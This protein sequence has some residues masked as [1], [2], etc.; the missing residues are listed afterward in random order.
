MAK[1]EPPPEPIF[2]ATPAEF[3]K[4]LRKNHDKQS[5]LWVGYHRKA[6]GRPSIT[7]PESVDEALCVGWIDG[8]RKRWD[9]DSYMIRFTPR[10]ERSTW[11]AINIA[12][13]AELT[14]AGRM[15]PAGLAA[16]ARR[17][18]DRSEIYA[19]EQRANAK[20]DDAAEQRLRA[21][22]KAWTFF[23]AQPPSYRKLMAWWII[24]AKRPET[25]EKRL[26]RLIEESA[27]GR[28]L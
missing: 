28:R 7:W 23:Q 1:S 3:R 6:T 11:S 19:Y 10:K 22:A 2:F 18:D 24:S 17:T 13:I 25:R 26:V 12:R 5:V 21:N 20:L 14:R 4:W 27:A 16:F 9:A 8:I 15:R